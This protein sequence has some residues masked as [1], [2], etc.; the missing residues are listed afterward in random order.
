VDL[1]QAG[2]SEIL[3]ALHKLVDRANRAGTVIYTMHTLGLQP[4][5]PNAQDRP[6]SNNALNALSQ[7]GLY[8][9]PSAGLGQSGMGMPQTGRDMAFSVGQQGLAYLALET[10][11]LP[12]ENGNDL[13]WGLDRV[14]EDQQG[15]YLIGF[16]P[17]QGTFDERH[18]A[19]SYHHVTVGVTRPGLH[20]RSRSGFF[21]ETDDETLTKYKTPSEQMRVAMFSPF[22]SAAVRLR[23]TSLY[24]EAAKR[25]PVVR[26]LLHIDTRDLTFRA[27]HLLNETGGSDAAVEIEAVAS[28]FSDLPVASVARYYTVHAPATGFEE[29][30]NAGVLYS[31]DVPVKKRGA[32]QIHV[33][34][35]D[36]AT[37]K[38]GSASQFLE[39]PEIKKG[40]VA[41]T[42][43][44]LQGDGQR[45][46]MSPATRQ[47]RTGSQ[48]EYV[49]V[50]ESS[51]DI[52]AAADLH[53][54]I[55]IVRDG[56]DIYAG[57]A[58][59]GRIAGGGLAVSGTLKLNRL[60]TPG[61]YYMGI[62][63]V[64]RTALKRT[65]FTQWTDFEVV[66]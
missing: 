53:A 60:L 14:L 36:L 9:S 3:D 31:L 18:G 27:D 54:Q 26:N 65:A 59:L 37:G 16:K 52:S 8:T 30:Q 17:P 19:R 10:G 55:R 58:N 24:A 46:D 25:G 63:V 28:S 5:V 45:G 4:L 35:R 21:G 2:N 23:L 29:A 22:R 6:D 44:V 42:S 64:D 56:K 39:I 57:P 48:V 1:S 49:S 51:G 15:Y 62:V 43:I 38:T 12:Y 11:G 7:V 50:I 66:P 41:L 32:Y 47:F 34:V 20:V 13:N 61:D 33:A 40:R